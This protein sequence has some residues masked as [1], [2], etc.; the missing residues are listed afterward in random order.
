MTSL[1]DCGCCSGITAVTPVDIQNRPGLTTI[2]YRPGTFQQ[3]KET[4]LARLSSATYPALRDLTTRD[5]SDFSIALLDAFSVV[6]DVLAFY[7]ERMANEN[8]LRTA[9]ERLSILQLARLIGYQLRPGVAA[10]AFL[11]FTM[12][13]A[14][15]AFGQGLGLT[16]SVL[17]GQA[18]P[19]VPPPIVIDIGTKVQSVPGPG[20]KTQTFETVE[21]IEARTFWN[22]I[23]PRPTQPIPNFSI[24]SDPLIVAGTPSLKNGD[25]VLINDGTN[26]KLR[27]ILTVA[28]DPSANITQINF[29]DPPATLTGFTRPSLPVGTVGEFPPG[30]PLDA[31]VAQKIIGEQWDQP[32]LEALAKT[33]NWPLDSLTANIN[34]QAGVSQLPQGAGIFVLRQR[35]GIF[36]NTAPANDLLPA[37]IRGLVNDPDEQSLEDDTAGAQFTGTQR[38]IFLDNT[39]PA[40]VPQSWI[41]LTDDTGDQIPFQ[42][43]ANI[44][45]S[46]ADYAISGKISRITVNASSPFNSNLTVRKTAVF[47]QSEPLQLAQIPINDNIARD[48]ITLDATYLELDPGKTVILTGERSDLAGV[49]VSENRA[50]KQALLEHGFTVLIFDKPLTFSYLR[51]SVTINANVALATHGESVQET[52]GNGNASTPFQAFPLKQPPL[53]YVTATND[54]GAASTLSVRVNGLLWN[55]VPDLF[56]HGPAERIYRIRQEDGGN[57]TVVFG[58]GDTGARLP[59]GVENILAK[60]RRGIGVAGLVKADQISQLANRPLGVKGVT[61]PLAATGAQDPENLD[62]ARVYAPLQILTLGRIVSLQDYEDFAR[63]FSGIGKALATWTWNGEV[64]GVFLTIAGVNGADVDPS[65]PLYSSLINAIAAAGDPH[66]PLNV[67]NFRRQFFGF[68]AFVKVDPAFDSDTVLAAV[69]QAVRSAFSFDNRAFGQSVAQSEITEVMHSVPGVIAVDIENLLRNDGTAPVNGILPAAAP[70]PGSTGATGAEL[71]IL[72]PGPLNLK[73]LK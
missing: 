1:N 69:E 14:P 54:T 30:T 59:T 73:V 15:G 68:S 5:D 17:S 2:A 55:E 29:S 22:A 53:T 3:F 8:Y 47:A 66:V 21:A 7:N 60:Y 28:P 16:P 24:N 26:S 71:L 50:I 38:V 57:S 51:P 67:Q 45:V 61:N 37:D 34:S 43:V 52:L 46:R 48:T 35:A 13:Q 6:A 39:Y 25:V 20:E 33:Q 40:I 23:P 11:A 58:D 63:A 27:T 32:T 70:I 36:G 41:V 56:G 49:T 72:D 65:Q 10:S 18:P 42:V 31:T 12:E 4:L 19:P 64:R 44:D 9:T 62:Q